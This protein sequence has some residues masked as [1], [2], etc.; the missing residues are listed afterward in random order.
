MGKRSA[1][2]LA[3][4]RKAD[5]LEFLLVQPGGPFWAKKDAGVWS[6][7]KGEFEEDEERALRGLRESLKRRPPTE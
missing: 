7:P 3:Y 5:A 4:R 2:I 1:G 6:I